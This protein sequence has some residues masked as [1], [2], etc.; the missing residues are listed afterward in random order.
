[1][2]QCTKCG[3][4]Y[5]N[6]NFNMC[7]NCGNPLV[8]VQSDNQQTVYVNQGNTNQG[9]ANPGY[10]NQ[11][12]GAV[13]AQPWMNQTAN[14]PMPPK[15]KT[16][17]PPKKKGSKAWIIVLCTLLLLAIGGGVAAFLIITAKPKADFYTKNLPIELMEYEME[18]FNYTSDLVEVKILNEEKEDGVVQAECE[19]MLTDSRMDRTLYYTL[20]AQKEDGEWEITDYSQNKEDKIS[21]KEGMAEAIVDDYAFE[22]LSNYELISDYDGSGFVF[23]YDVNDT[24]EFLKIN[25][26]AEFD[27]EFTR[28]DSD[29]IWYSP[30]VKINEDNLKQE[31]DFSGSYVDDVD[32][33]ETTLG[34]R[35]KQDGDNAQ[36]EFYTKEFGEETGEATIEK[37][38][39]NYYSKTSLCEIRYE[40]LKAEYYIG[41][42]PDG[43]VVSS[44]TGRNGQIID[45]N[46]IAGEYTVEKPEVNPG[47][48]SAGSTDIVES[49]PSVAY[50]TNLE[51]P[52]YVYSWNHEVGE[53]IDTH[54]R[55]RY[56]EL[57][58]LVVY[59]NLNEVGT[60]GEYSTDIQESM[61][62]DEV[63]S[64]VAYD[65]AVVSNFDTQ[66]FF[67]PVSQV[68]ITD[69]MYQ[70][71]YEYTKQ[72]VTFDNELMALS[73]QAA[74]GCF[75]YD[76]DIAKNVLGV[77][78]PEE[79]NALIS[80]WDDFLDTA[81]KLKDAGYYIVPSIEDITTGEGEEVPQNVIDEL[82][83]KE[84]V[85][86]CRQW[87]S[88]WSTY[89]EN[90]F[91]YFGCTWF[92]HWSLGIM[93]N[94]EDRNVATCEG[95]RA[96][97]WGGSYLGVT[98]ECA[99]PE[100]AGL[101]LYTLCCEDEVM[102]DMYAI[103]NYDM[104]NNKKAVRN[105]IIDGHGE[106]DYMN[107]QNL[108]PLWDNMARKINF[109]N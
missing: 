24:T 91:G 48:Q 39:L 38:S 36:L 68:G 9:I 83:S 27:V 17:K 90:V 25:G 59:V 35:I 21:I 56:P 31:W 61:Y 94:T 55:T 74:P 50:P 5:D 87:D 6:D 72:K 88:E 79:M 19:I 66:G 67:V 86:D 63:P 4:V 13:N 106:I 82:I 100:L 3:S 45:Q 14:I 73:W 78:T 34:F 32:D 105:L 53:K 69:E 29:E 99:N 16:E 10:A 51:E 58:D 49:I 1:M 104:P 75:T 85:G 18:N 12:F 96:Y 54:F 40:S 33:D 98:E 15:A 97:F 47:S 65:T 102:Y 22:N 77:S 8:T 57:S 20:C 76:A 11:N 101:V 64:I 103:S 2:K 42:Y 26:K 108:L 95:P 93:D 44:A 70:N 80:N 30:H 43:R 92:V 71:A 46:M 107:N 37:P 28:L 89:P 60:T 7:G 62:S 23:A 84:Y 52:I 81:K 109:G 41:I